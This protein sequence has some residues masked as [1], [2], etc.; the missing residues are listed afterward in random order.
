M[1]SL[2]FLYLYIANAIIMM[3]NF[4][5]K[6]HDHYGRVKMV[7]FVTK[8]LIMPLLAAYYYFE[9]EKLYTGVIAYTILHWFGDMVLFF[10][11]KFSLLVG[12][13]SF[14]IGHITLANAF[15]INWSQF[16][17]IAIFPVSYTHLTLPTN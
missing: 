9:S 3:I 2:I 15:T 4:F 16:P 8:F 17:V 12:G 14:T 13:I 1:E 11:Y 6:P 10:N 5:L 7:Y